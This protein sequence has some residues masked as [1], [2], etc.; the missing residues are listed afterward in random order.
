MSHLNAL[1][2]PRAVAIIGASTKELSIGNVITKNLQT[3]GYRGAIYPINPSAPDIRGITAYKSL[4]EIP[5][6][7]D[8]AHIIIPSSQVP[9]AMEECGRKGVKAV[10]INSAG[11]S[12]MGEDGARLQT[13]FLATAQKY[14]VRVFGPNCQGIINSDPEL[15]AYCNFTFTYPEPG[16]IS[17][18]ALS[19]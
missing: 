4:A 16:Y 5:G 6:E 8:L 10:I 14:G 1:F 3:Y 15:K 13:E 19:G 11:F 12:E 18:V 9:Q 7:V 2:S 17:V